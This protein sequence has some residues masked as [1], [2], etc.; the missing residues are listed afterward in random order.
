MG[1]IALLSFSE[2]TGVFRLDKP[3]CFI[4]GNFHS[5]HID[6]LHCI[7]CQI[8]TSLIQ[9]YTALLSTRLARIVFRLKVYPL[10]STVCM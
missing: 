5:M 2:N 3:V 6:Q 10:R 8:S 9:V 4:L 1:R 7:L